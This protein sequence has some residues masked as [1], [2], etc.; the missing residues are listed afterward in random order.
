VTSFPSLTVAYLSPAYPLLL[1]FVALA[2]AIK[3][4]Q[5]H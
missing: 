3:A 1:I 4:E 5:R 2:L